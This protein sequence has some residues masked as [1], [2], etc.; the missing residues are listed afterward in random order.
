[1][2]NNLVKSSYLAQKRPKKGLKEVYSALQTGISS[3]RG[4][5]AGRRCAAFP[6]RPESNQNMHQNF[7]QHNG[8]K[9]P[10]FVPLCFLTNLKTKLIGQH[11]GRK[12]PIH[13]IL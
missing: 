3:V 2:Q 12:M 10:I 8:R 11:N 6:P 13:E 5:E 4:V 1:M 9:T 7:R